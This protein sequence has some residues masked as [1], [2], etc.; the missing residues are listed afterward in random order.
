VD[1]IPDS[2][3]RLCVP[4]NRLRQDCAASAGDLAAPGHEPRRGFPNPSVWARRSSLA[5]RNGRK[6][7][8]S[9]PQPTG[10]VQSREC[11][12]K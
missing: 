1:S 7:E 11:R 8:P 12:S 9:A 3:D 5:G 10:V 2:G 4:G 6:I